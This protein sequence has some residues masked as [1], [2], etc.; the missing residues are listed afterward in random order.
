MEVTVY[1]P[2]PPDIVIVVILKLAPTTVN[3]GGTGC[4]AVGGVTGGVGVA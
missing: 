3:A 4:I 2:T 1:G